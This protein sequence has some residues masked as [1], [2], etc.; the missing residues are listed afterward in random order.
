MRRWT[1]DTFEARRIRAIQKGEIDSCDLPKRFGEQGYRPRRYEE[2]LAER[3]NKRAVRVGTYEP[4]PAYLS[5]GE[6]ACV[7]KTGHLPMCRGIGEI[8]ALSEIGEAHL[9][10]GQ[11]EGGEKTGLT[12]RPKDRRKKGTL[13]SHILD[14]IIQLI[15]SQGSGDEFEKREQS[16]PVM[17]VLVAPGSQFSG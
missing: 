3:F 1:L 12:I 16:I 11:D 4:G 2:Y 6:D 5:F 15:D 8:G 10:P 17:L 14:N 7:E 13:S 9:V